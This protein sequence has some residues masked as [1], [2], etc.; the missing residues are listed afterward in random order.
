MTHAAKLRELMQGNG[1]IAPGMFDALTGLLIQQQGFHC[2]YLGGASIAYS[3]L[4]L[5]D[6]GLVSFAEVAQ[7]VTQIRE[8]VDIPFIVDAD[9][10]FGNAMNAQRTI[11]GLERAGASAFRSKIKPCRNAAGI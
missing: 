6:I 2:A 7:V 5:P 9:T 11:R 1:F 4:G 10:G 8:R 3:R